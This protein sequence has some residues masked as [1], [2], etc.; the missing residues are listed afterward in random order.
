MINYSF[1][2]ATKYVRK[3]NWVAINTL[4]VGLQRRL[5]A[6][7]CL[8]Q[9]RRFVMKEVKDKVNHR[10][11][12]W[13]WQSQIQQW[14]EAP[15]LWFGPRTGAAVAAAPEP[16]LPSLCPWKRPFTE[17]L[18]LK[19]RGWRGWRWGLNIHKRLKA[20][21]QS[22]LL[23]LNLYGRADWVLWTPFCALLGFY[24]E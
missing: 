21:R 14:T 16:W 8:V 24:S 17:C 6:F 10:A 2:S 18:L 7:C 4:T 3:L 1:P 12:F 5:A 11:V 20:A 15:S 19:D 9:C 13:G 22:N 23:L